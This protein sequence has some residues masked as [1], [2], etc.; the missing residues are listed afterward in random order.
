MYTL[1][2]YNFPNRPLPG[3]VKYL[4]ITV[5]HIASCQA[6]VYRLAPFITEQMKFKTKEPAHRTFPNFSQPLEHFVSP[7]SFVMTNPN[8]GTVYVCYARTILQNKSVSRKERI[9]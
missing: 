7:Y 4:L 3:H 9:V 1:S 5:V 6:E 8:A 2:A